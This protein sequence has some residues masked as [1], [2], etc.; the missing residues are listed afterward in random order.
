MTPRD[1]HANATDLFPRSLSALT[2]MQRKAAAHVLEGRSAC[3]FEAH[4]ALSIA[5]IDEL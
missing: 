1:R 2:L 4:L 5:E 3:G